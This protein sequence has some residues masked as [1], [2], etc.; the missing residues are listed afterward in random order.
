VVP[1]LPC[2]DSPGGR[3]T[4]I[5]GTRAVSSGRIWYAGRR[6]RGSELTFDTAWRTSNPAAVS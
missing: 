2:N 4:L 5:Y 1:L 3:A 6:E